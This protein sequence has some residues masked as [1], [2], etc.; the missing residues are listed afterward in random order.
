MIFSGTL[1]LDPAHHAA[2]TDA[3]RARL[4][5]LEQRRRSAGQAVELVLATWHGE[6]AERFRLHWEEW[7][8]GVFLVV[9]RLAAGIAALDRVRDEAVAVDVG[10]AASSATLAGRLG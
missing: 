4:T 6:A 3:L 9:E 5:D 1:A 2:S 7:D 10:C 8:R